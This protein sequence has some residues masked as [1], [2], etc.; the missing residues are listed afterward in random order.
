MGSNF[1]AMQSSVQIPLRSTQPFGHSLR[2]VWDEMTKS[3]T[4]RKDQVTTWRK[5]TDFLGLWPKIGHQ[6]RDSMGQSGSSS[7]FAAKPMG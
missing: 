1:E 5:P 3:E 6:V 4:F 2:T 7:I